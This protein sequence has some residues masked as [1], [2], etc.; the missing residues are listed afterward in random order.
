MDVGCGTG[1]VLEKV[2]A[3]GSWSGVGVD[4]S[5]Q[6][7]AYAQK[8]Y[9]KFEILE[10]TATQLPFNDQYFS[11]IVCL[12][13]M[14]YIPA[15]ALALAEISR[16]M[17]KQ[18]DVIISIPN[19]N[20]LFRKLRKIEFFLFSPFKRL[21]AKITGK[22]HTTNKICHQQW[23]ADSFVLQLNAVG[24]QVQSLNYCTYGVLSPKLVRDKWN[25]NL[26]LWLTK[27]INKKPLF[28]RYLANTIVIHAKAR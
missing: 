16:I 24:L 9:P 21:Q 1:N 7:V 11:V 15:Y 5:P 14:E 6:M 28:N 27:K 17:T 25:I 3:L 19:K 22:V 23:T 18:G 13:V 8:K 10:A 12:G 20:S 26:S 4:I 2:V